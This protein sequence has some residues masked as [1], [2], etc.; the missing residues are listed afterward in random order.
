MAQGV[1]TAIKREEPPGRKATIDRSG[2]QSELDQLPPGNHTMLPERHLRQGAVQGFVQLTPYIGVRCTHPPVLA[3]A[4]AWSS[5]SR[6]SAAC[7]IPRRKLPSRGPKLR[8]L[9]RMV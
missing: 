8:S 6:S 5:T 9:A 1:N 2:A 3:A 4:R 7:D